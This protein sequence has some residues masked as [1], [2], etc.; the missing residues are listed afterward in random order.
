MVRRTHRD[1][2]GDV[3]EIDAGQIY[4]PTGGN[5]GTFQA[6]ADRFFATDRIVG[7]R[8]DFNQQRG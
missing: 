3:G 7:E 8:R 5:T 4:R 2:A 6:Q 1:E